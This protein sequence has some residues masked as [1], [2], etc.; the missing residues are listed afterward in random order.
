MF[1]EETHIWDLIVPTLWHNICSRIKQGNVVP[2][3]WHVGTVKS[4]RFNQPLCFSL[5][6]ITGADLL[7]TITFGSTES[8]NHV[9]ALWLADCDPLCR[10][11]Y[12]CGEPVAAV[13][14]IDSS[15]TCK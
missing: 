5:P 12:F 10:F 7:K 3:C 8:I 15:K 9:R 14:M 1:V 4:P 13:I 11:L 2:T 6:S